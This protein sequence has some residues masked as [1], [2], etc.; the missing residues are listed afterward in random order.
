MAEGVGKGK[1]VK[2]KGAEGTEETEI[3]EKGRA[4]QAG[5]EL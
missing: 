4:I 1:K 5:G 2:E 3:A